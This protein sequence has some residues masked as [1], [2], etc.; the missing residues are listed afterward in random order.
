MQL[1]S[2]EK[3]V[4]YEEIKRAVE[5]GLLEHVTGT[6]VNEKSWAYLD[7]KVFLALSLSILCWIGGSWREQGSTFEPELPDAAVVC[8]ALCS[9]CHC[10][11]GVVACA[12]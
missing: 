8:Q 10:C 11:L 1:P 6:D 7:T 2:L 5:K 12:N 4:Q 3:Y 9:L